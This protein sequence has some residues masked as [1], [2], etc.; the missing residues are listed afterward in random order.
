[1]YFKM[2]MCWT[3]LYYTPDVVPS[4]IHSFSSYLSK[5][6]CEQELALG[7]KDIA[8]RVD[9]NLPPSRSFSKQSRKLSGG[10]DYGGQ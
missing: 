7:A 10:Q 8:N 6:S 4:F 9:T 2:F 1:M 5:A 3:L